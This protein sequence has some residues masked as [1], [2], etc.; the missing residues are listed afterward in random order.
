MIVPRRYA[1][2]SRPRPSTPSFGRSGR[3]TRSY[4][5]SDERLR[6][7][8]MFA[9]NQ[10]RWPRCSTASRMRRR[11]G[12]LSGRCLRCRLTATAA[13]V[14]RLDQRRAARQSCIWPAAVTAARA[15]GWR[16]SS[17][18]VWRRRPARRAAPAPLRRAAPPPRYPLCRRQRYPRRRA[19]PALLRRPRAARQHSM[20]AA[21]ASSP[22]RCD[23]SSPRPGAR[24]SGSSTARSA[25][26][27]GWRRP[28][29]GRPSSRAGCQ[30]S[31]AAN[32]SRAMCPAATPARHR[33]ARSWRSAAPSSAPMLT[34]R[35]VPERTAGHHC[36]AAVWRGEQQ[37]RRRRHRDAT[38]RL[39]AALRRRQR[40]L[41][42]GRT[43][44][45]QHHPAAVERQRQPAHAAL[46]GARIVAQHHQGRPAMAGH[47]H[48]IAVP[49]RFRQD[50]V[51]DRE[52]RAPLPEHR[53]R[54]HLQLR[55]HSPQQ[56]NRHR[57]H[58]VRRVPQRRGRRGETR[59]RHAHRGGRTA[60]APG[61]RHAGAA[62]HHRAGKHQL[63]GQ[64]A[65]PRRLGRIRPRHAQRAH[66]PA[67]QLQIR[68]EPAIGMDH[69]PLIERS[70]HLAPIIRPPL[71]VRLAP[72]HPAIPRRERLSRG[73]GPP[74]GTIGNDPLCSTAT[75]PS[76]MAVN[77]CIVLPAPSLSHACRGS[78]CG[79]A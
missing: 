33:R 42:A 56:R 13:P 75:A 6:N 36:A 28:F 62:Q 60:A 78:F 39:A 44:R 34:M 65:P 48:Q 37:V 63:A 49:A 40:G 23:P 51:V 17:G 35:T 71:P 45:G 53:L 29:A 8:S 57:I 18:P 55:L 27:P 22:P 30:H 64:V 77:P 26:Q 79:C 68:H 52:R 47:A 67:A 11:S 25:S 16:G 9:A 24:A 21:A 50:A 46:H 59:N 1:C 5:A 74:I 70:T 15:P 41:H 66:H 12:P 19:A 54:Q 61:Q 4:L 2:N 76:I 10:A 20:S 38:A 32:S 14:G 31:S 7:G 3:S 58:G 69:Q 72:D 73:A 43:G